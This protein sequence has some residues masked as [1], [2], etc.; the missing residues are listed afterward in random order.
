[1]LRL[2]LACALLWCSLVGYL[3][4]SKKLYSVVLT[5]GRALP[6]VGETLFTMLPVYVG[7]ALFGIRSA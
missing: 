7:Y 4:H 2:V 3:A 6:R 1:M 5:I